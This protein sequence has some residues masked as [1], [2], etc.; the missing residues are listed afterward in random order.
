MANSL[1]F[2]LLRQS[3][4]IFLFSSFAFSISP[5]DLPPFFFA[6]ITFS[7]ASPTPQLLM[8]YGY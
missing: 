8:L 6:Q 4:H 3:S 7:V 1:S 5:L 2:G